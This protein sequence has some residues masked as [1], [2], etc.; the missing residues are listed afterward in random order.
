MLDTLLEI[1]TPE[2]VALRLRAAGPV[3]RALA[4][5]IDL[6]VRLTLVWVLAMLLSLLGK[7]GS[8]VFLLALFLV[9]WAYPVLFE[10]LRGGQTIGKSVL[11]LRVVGDNGAPIG[12]VASIVRNLMRTVDMFPVFYGFGLASTLIDPRAR[13]LG[14]MVAGTLVV[15]ADAAAAGHGRPAEDALPPAFALRPDEQ[16]ALVGFAERAAQITGERQRELADLLAPATRLTGEA[17]V[18]RLLANANWL[19]GRR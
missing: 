5:T 6:G 2:G 1:Q 11:G 14:D 4:W 10:A 16:S 13:R 12:W 15:H 18:R 9:Y 7:G 8:G 19:V 17:A 3:P